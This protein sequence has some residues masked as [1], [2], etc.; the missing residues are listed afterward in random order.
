[1]FIF[2]INNHTFL[3]FFFLLLSIIDPTVWR[4]CQRNCAAKKKR[5]KSNNKKISLK[6]C[7]TQRVNLKIRWGNDRI[8]V[9]IADVDK[10]KSQRGRNKVTLTWFKQYK[11]NS[12]PQIEIQ[13]PSW[14]WS[15][16]SWIYN[17]LCN[18]CISPLTLWV[19]I[20]LKAMC[21]RYNIMW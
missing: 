3:F 6:I 7:T 9:K 16:G 5:K 13:K 2:H 10:K 4:L 14:S 1:M 11:K 20:P 21:T 12:L 8:K 18:Q 17:F 19:R 15:Y